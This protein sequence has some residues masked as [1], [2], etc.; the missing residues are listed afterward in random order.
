MAPA[1]T[2]VRIPA[3]AYGELEDFNPPHDFDHG[4]EFEAATPRPVPKSYRSG[5]YASRHRGAVYSLIWLGAMFIVF[6]PL[7]FVQG[8]AH[9]ILPLA[10][11]HWI[12]FGL[13]AIAAYMFLSG[14]AK[15]GRYR[16]I[17]EAKPFVG[18]ILEVDAVAGGTQ[19]HPQFKFAAQVQYRHP[20]TDQLKLA[21]VEA[22]DLWGMSEVERH[23]CTLQRG[24]YV[25]L[26]GLPGKID[27][28]LK[29]FGFLGLDPEREFLLKD[30]FPMRGTSPFTA[31]MIA[32]LI[33]GIVV[34]IMAAC[35]VMMFSFP[36]SGDWKLPVALTVG[37]LVFGGLLGLGLSVMQ[38]SEEKS[39]TNTL[40]ALWVC[41]IF[42]A[43]GAPLLLIILNSRLDREA[44]KLEPIEIVNFWQTTHNFIFRDY[45]VEYRS[46]QAGGATKRHVRYS[47]LERIG[48]AGFGVVEVGPGRFGYP[49]VRGIHPVIWAPVEEAQDVDGPE[50]VVTIPSEEGG[51]API[52]TTIKPVIEVEDGSLHAVPEILIEHSVNELATAGFGIEPTTPD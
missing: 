4:E 39:A 21:I 23:Q 11:L 31:M 49:W 17:R 20:E 50:Y 34:L 37:G 35:D 36:L 14:L 51:A 16:Y 9:Y 44:P 1:K 12:G 45:E 27:E 33:G 3:S 19:E 43:V 41:A 18:R 24:D 38:R 7:P 25:T 13:L 10:W 28:T 30:D 42:G 40:G 46:L 15:S 48:D 52:V 47:Q 26:V 2:P 29:I 5:S 6:W 22:E 8:L 32:F